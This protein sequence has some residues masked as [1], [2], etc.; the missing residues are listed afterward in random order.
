[1]SDKAREGTS[2]AASE[3]SGQAGGKQ[4]AAAETKE[5]RAAAQAQ[6]NE[7]SHFCC[8]WGCKTL[9][10][11]AAAHCKRKGVREEDW[12][13]LD[14]KTLLSGLDKRA[15][16]SMR[17]PSRSGISEGSQQRGGARPGSQAKPPN[18]RKP[19]AM[20]DQVTEASISQSTKG[21]EERKDVTESMHKSLHCCTKP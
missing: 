17:A 20:R 2:Q 8:S 9:R 14:L 13:A 4:P 19:S 6:Q 16:A 7:T 10:T 18:S 15:L 3:A 5:G 21:G 1:M 11:D 12:A